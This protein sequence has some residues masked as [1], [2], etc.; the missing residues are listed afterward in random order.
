MNTNDEI[1]TKFLA[2]KT[3]ADV[4]DLLEIK[5]K[6]LRYFLYA[7]KPD[8]MY[9]DFKIKKKN[10]EDRHIHAPDKRLKSIQRKLADVL[11]SVYKIKPAAHGFVMDKNIITNASCHLKRKYVFNMDLENFFE[12]IHFGRIRGMLMKPPY[13]IGEEAATVIAQLACYKGKLPQ[14]APT[15][16][17]LT[18]MICSPLDTKLS[19]LAKKHNVRYSR[20]ADDITFSSNNEFPEEIVYSDLTGIHVGKELEDIIVKNSFLVNNRKTRVYSY[21]KRQEV[22]GLVVN[23]IVNIRRSYVKEVRAILEQCRRQG[24]YEAAKMFIE[25]GKCK[26]T[27]IVEAV[28]KETE[29]NKEIVQNWF[30]AVLKG[31]IGYIKQVKGADNYVFLKYAYELNE[32]FDEEVFTISKEQELIEK[33]EK[34]V[35][36]IEMETDEE[37]YQGSGFIAKGLGLLTNDHVTEV[38]GIYNVN[39]YTG[40]RICALSNDMNLKKRNRNIDYACYKFGENS[41]DAFDLGT[42][43]NLKIGSRVLLVGYPDYNKGNSPEIQQT[44]VISSRLYM[45]QRIYTVSARVVHGA[46][47]GVVLDESHKVVGIINCGVVSLKEESDNSIQG[48]IPIDEVLNDLKEELSTGSCV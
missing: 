34:A 41:E 32:V 28:K 40:K 22:T 25:K 11:N 36:I 4:A 21:K 5:E 14:G 10:G 9:Y 31:K 30:K 29:E 17:I 16:P 12:Q 42:S 13:G 7:V 47:G 20:Y 15:S 1:K 19:K 48:F 39:S 33:V 8:N 26:N 23:E 38:E 18:N 27:T 24:I 43:S 6:S 35:F 44:E 45:G 3:R 2:L 46:S 37:Y